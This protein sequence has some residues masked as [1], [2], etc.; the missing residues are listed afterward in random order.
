M[1]IKRQ[2]AVIPKGQ[3][4][5]QTARNLPCPRSQSWWKK[6]HENPDPPALCLIALSALLP[7]LSAGWG[8]QDR[9]QYSSYLHSHCRKYCVQAYSVCFYFL[10]PAQLICLTVRSSAWHTL[11]CVYIRKEA[12]PWIMFSQLV[13]ERERPV[14]S[15]DSSSNPAKCSVQPH[16][17]L[18]WWKLFS[19]HQ[20]EE[21]EIPQSFLGGI[22][23]VKSIQSQQFTLNFWE[24][25][26]G[27]DDLE[28]RPQARCY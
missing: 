2:A 19:F 28:K 13:A 12:F 4:R 1:L 15:L 27:V 18:C 6:Q 16:T 23:R 7:K 8:P 24:N 11:C 5:S 21:T 9:N 25:K 22:Y 14:S 10:E 3:V 17:W 26:R 20:R